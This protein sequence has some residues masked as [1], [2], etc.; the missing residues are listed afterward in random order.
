MSDYPLPQMAVAVVLAR[1]SLDPRAI[2]QARAALKGVGS[3]EPGIAYLRNGLLA[4]EGGQD[5]AEAARVADVTPDLMARALECVWYA[6]PTPALVD[7]LAGYLSDT[8]LR[9]VVWALD[10]ATTEPVEASAP[11]VPAW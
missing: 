5:I 10:G 9:R 6:P 7:A 8:D 2:A 1:A 11:G 3:A 4:L